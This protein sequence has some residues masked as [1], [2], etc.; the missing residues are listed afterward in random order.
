[1][2]SGEACGGSDAC[3]PAVETVGLGRRSLQDAGQPLGTSKPRLLVG[4]TGLGVK[5]RPVPLTG[6]VT[7]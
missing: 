1:M 5:A 3:E 7:S 2:C 4:R 6:L